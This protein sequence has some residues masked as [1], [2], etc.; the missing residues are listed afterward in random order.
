M[1]T[2]VLSGGGNRG[3]LEVGALR[4]LFE[5]GIRVDMLVGTSAGALNATALACDPTPAG[6]DRLASLWTSAAGE[7]IFP[8]GFF[9]QAVRF[10]T[11]QDSLYP[12]GGLR[13]FVQANLPPGVRTFGDVRVRLYLISANL[14][15]ATLYVFGEEP[16]ASLVDAALA[17]AA[18]PPYFPPVTVAGWQ[19]V[20]GGAVANVP[21]SVAIDLGAREIYAIDVSYAGAV[22]RAVH[23]VIPVAL[24]TIQTLMYQQLLD[25]L[26]DVAARSDV[27]LHHLRIDAFQELAVTDLSKSREMIE[28]GYRQAKAQLARP[29]AA[30]ASLAADPP[31]AP[32]PPGARVWRRPVA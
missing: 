9:S 24:Q 23:G 11:G 5:A 29:V 30:A 12:N 7:P 28:E 18:F 27:T 13:R 31:P 1:I 14:N 20:D 25:D 6:V 32:P 16:S 10:L 4:A 15:T 17:S 19:Y 2:V 22:Q 21:L 26:Q 3:A 8:G